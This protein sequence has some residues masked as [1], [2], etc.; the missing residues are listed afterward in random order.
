MDRVA[1][2]PTFAQDGRLVAPPEVTIFELY[3]KI[4]GGSHL[5][6]EATSW[7]ELWANYYDGRRRGLYVGVIGTSERKGQDPKDVSLYR[8]ELAR[9]EARS[10]VLLED[11]LKMRVYVR[12]LP[13]ERVNEISESWYKGQAGATAFLLQ[14]I[15]LKRAECA[16]RGIFPEPDPRFWWEKGE[17]WKISTP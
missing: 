4:S 3:A 14:Q 15:A 16:R 7:A 17:P 11:Y 8:K 12:N 13:A 2:T 6:L 5:R 10:C 1:Y 9:I